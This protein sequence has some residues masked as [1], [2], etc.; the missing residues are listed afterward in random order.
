MCRAAGQ[1]N[2][3]YSYI[4]TAQEARKALVEQVAGTLT[5]YAARAAQ[6]GRLGAKSGA[7]SVVQRTSSDLRLNQRS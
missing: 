4:N 6:E 5:F 3:N 1:G 7:V 2:G